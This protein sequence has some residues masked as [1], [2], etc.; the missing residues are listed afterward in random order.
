MDVPE[1]A[2]VRDFE[3]DRSGRVGRNVRR[4][5][6]SVRRRGGVRFAGQQKAMVIIGLLALI[7][8][9]WIF[10]LIRRRRNQKLE[11]ASPSEHTDA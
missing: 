10:R 8:I 7:L 2:A 4:R 6:L 11:T 5:P 1:R 9:V 3:R